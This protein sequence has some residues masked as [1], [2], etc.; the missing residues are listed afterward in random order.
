MKKIIFFILIFI[1]S[2]SFSEEIIRI[3]EII[4]EGHKKTKEQTI[5]DI[6]KIK[7][8][9]IYNAENNLWKYFYG[10]GTGFSVYLKGVAVPA[11][12]MY[13]A[14][15]LENLRFEGSFSLGLSF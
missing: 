1:S 10:P 3:N 6:I 8:G 13:A 7:S 4:I 15:N 2:I 9:D 14:Y 12:G 11:L 5:L